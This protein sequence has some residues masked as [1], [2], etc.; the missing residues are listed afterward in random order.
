MPRNQGYDSTIDP[1]YLASLFR[2]TITQQQYLI[3]LKILQKL[4]AEV[5]GT[6]D[7]EFKDGLMYRVKT[8]EELVDEIIISQDIKVYYNTTAYWNEQP[9]LLSEQGAIYIYSDAKTFEGAALP[10]VKIGTGNAYLIDLHFI[11]D[12]IV[13]QLAH[14]DTVTPQEKEKW[15]NKVTCYLDSNDNESLIFSKD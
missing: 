14:I 3:L 11:D 15:N 2:G 4:W 13:Y 12:D 9:T 5:E 10:R 6:E 8:L 1:A 7:Q